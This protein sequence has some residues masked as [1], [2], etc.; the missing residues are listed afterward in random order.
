[1]KTLTGGKERNAIRTMLRRALKDGKLLCRR[2]YYDYY[3][4]CHV[5]EETPDA[6]WTV[7]TDD[8]SRWSRDLKAG[9]PSVYRIEG[10]DVFELST[11]YSTYEVKISKGVEK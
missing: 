10:S 4:S 1:M 8:A 7:A 9:G 5:P 6:P 3:D 2:T 11:G